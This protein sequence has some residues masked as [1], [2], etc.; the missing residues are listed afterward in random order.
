[1]VGA[2]KSERMLLRAGLSRLPL[3][4]TSQQG[5]SLIELSIVLIII[6][7]IVGASVTIW[8]SSIGAT[9]LSTTKTNLDNIKTSIIN[10]AIANGR[11]PC[12]DTTIPPNNTGFSNPNNPT[13]PPP[14]NNCS[15]TCPAP[16]CFVPFQTLQLTLAKGKD[17]F[18]NAFFYDT[19]YDIAGTGGLTNT[20]TDT[21]CG[22]LYEY[23]SKSAGV[24]ALP[25]PYVTDA[26]GNSYSVAAVIISE[27]SIDNFFNVPAPPAPGLTGMNLGPHVATNPRQ[28]NSANTANVPGPVPPPYGDLV[29]EV[30]YGDLYNKA[31][32][33]QKTKIRIQNYSGVN[34][35]A[36]INGA[37]C[38]PVQGAPAGFIDIFQG[39]TIIFYSDALCSSFCG[40][41]APG[42]RFTFNM[43]AVN[44]D[45]GWVDWNSGTA[46]A[47]DGRVQIPA[48]ATCGALANLTDNTNAAP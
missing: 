14:P 33:M 31:C 24:P 13:P 4:L 19:S 36:N 15:L 35:W 21:F 3:R 11:L 10:F 38:V 45:A 23:S 39:T 12:A 27:T 8:R 48:G 41:V 44:T 2:K 22:V 7:L 9:K 16:P 17:S 42:T 5:F 20:T 18:G 29:A 43:S 46:L 1:M 32:T 47:R 30:T 28:Y 25:I 26:T 37:G 40:P 34:L 6:G